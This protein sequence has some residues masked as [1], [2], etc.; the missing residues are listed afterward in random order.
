MKNACC[1]DE[2]F[3]KRGGDV[4]R[5]RKRGVRMTVCLPESSSNSECERVGVSHSLFETISFDIRS[6]GP[7]SRSKSFA[8]VILSET[9]GHGTIATRYKDF[10][11]FSV[12]VPTRTS[13]PGRRRYLIRPP[14]FVEL[15]SNFSIEVVL[16][17][18]LSSFDTWSLRIPLLPR[19]SSHPPAPPL[20]SFTPQQ[21]NTPAQRSDMPTMTRPITDDDLLSLPLILFPTQ[22]HFFILL[23]CLLALI[24]FI[25]HQLKHFP[26]FHVISAVFV[27]EL[28]A[29]WSCVRILFLISWMVC[30]L[31]AALITHVF[32][33]L[34]G[35][36][37]MKERQ[38][39]LE[40]RQN[41]LEERTRA[42]EAQ[43]KDLEVMMREIRRLGNVVNELQEK[44][45][46]F[47]MEFE[48][49]QREWRY[50]VDRRRRQA[51]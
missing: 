48:R 14:R 2:Y 23:A 17:R 47:D 33:M 38:N 31:I 50:E 32:E 12:C 27:R 46:L 3:V 41:R 42:L 22:Y 7:W 19:A 30:L 25:L 13:E 11:Q 9:A 21:A 51:M 35:L 5:S 10:T 45:E 44:I 24:I 39:R 4:E 49:A 40:D 28:A 43:S 1:L 20:E 6:F 34:T 18:Q 15:R 29:T 37:S 26:R 16:L 36:R 8:A